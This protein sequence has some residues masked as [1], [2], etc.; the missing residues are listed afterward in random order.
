[1]TCPECL[2]CNDPDCGGDCVADECTCKMLPMPS[3]LERV[4]RVTENHVKNREGKRWSPQDQLAKIQEECAK[5]AQAGEHNDNL[6]TL[7]ECWDTIFAVLT[8]MH[9]KGFPPEVIQNGC[10]STL[11]KIEN[12]QG[13]KR[14]GDQAMKPCQVCG[15]RSRPGDVFYLDRV[16]D[17]WIHNGCE[18]KVS[19]IRES[20]PEKKTTGKTKV[21]T[22][23]PIGDT[24]PTT[25]H[26]T[27]EQKMKVRVICPVCDREV[28]GYGVEVC[29]ACKCCIQC[30]DDFSDIG[31][32]VEGRE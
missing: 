22:A 7:E 6:H 28:E 27:W 2:G 23:H 10:L 12:S 29:E 31:C 16:H 30:H 19:D 11:A 17:R 20:C 13:H 14:H 26:A 1:M 24:R 25:S 21:E 15:E 18:D 5:L 8:Y 9:L 32:P 3:L 4:A